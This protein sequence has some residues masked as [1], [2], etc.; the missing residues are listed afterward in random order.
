MDWI[1][2]VGVVLAALLI[3]GPDIRRA[4][5][6]PPKVGRPAL[7][8]LVAAAFAYA[9]SGIFLVRLLFGG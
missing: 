1:I 6:A 3:V 9:M 2:S 7:A 8:I 5:R 4:M